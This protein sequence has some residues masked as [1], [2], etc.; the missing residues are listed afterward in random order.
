M[1]ACGVCTLMAGEVSAQV[2]ADSTRTGFFNATD[3]IRQKRYI[4]EGRTVDP[5]AKGKNF[6]LSV[7]AGMGKLAGGFASELPLTKEFGLSVLKDVTSF[8][9]YRLSV[10]GAVNDRIKHGGVEVD[11]LFRI[12]DYLAGYDPNRLWSAGTV[13]GVGGY[14][15]HRE[16]YGKRDFAL[17]LHG[18]LHIDYRMHEHLNLF[19]EPRVNLFTDGIDVADSRKKYDVGAQLLAGITYRFT[20]SVKNQWIPTNADALDNLFYEFYVGAQGDYSARVRKSPLM[21]GKLAPLGPTMGLSIGKWYAPLGIRGTLFGGYHKTISDNGQAVNKEVYAG[22]R[23][24][25]LLN[26]NR[27]F[28]YEAVD[29]KLEVNL[30]GGYELGFLGHRG[31][32][33]A[34]KVRPFTGPTAGGQLVYAVTSRIGVFGQA[35]WSR[36]NYTQTFVSGQ[37]Q[38]RRMQNLSIEMGVQYRRRAENIERNKYWFEPYSFVS[39]A[40][41]ANYPMRVGEYRVENMVKHLGQQFSLSYGRRWSRY[42][43]VR[44]TLE[45]GHL[46]YAPGSHAYPITLGIDYMV[47]LSALAAEYNPERICSVELFGGILYTHHNAGQK[48]YFGMQ[49]GLKESFRVNDRWG[50]FLEEALRVYKGKIIPGARGLTKKDFSMMPYANVGVNYY[51]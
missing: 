27:L 37:S 5:K 42:S 1:A 46:P 7:F 25:G 43:S 12:V 13:I 41:G 24:E 16:D 6:S 51:F 44:G 26:L 47:D 9:T 45:T 22:G 31:D 30:F 18:G 39:A 34:N 17:G 2:A 23:L 4:P 19:I 32:S 29:P 3:Y 50:V 14:W 10:M 8:N 38:D 49:G 35:R 11:H 33:Y 36:N 28:N 21:N 40:V 48:D 15:S 20:G